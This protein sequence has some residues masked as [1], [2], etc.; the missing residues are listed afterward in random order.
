MMI[1]NDVDSGTQEQA[2]TGIHSGTDDESLVCRGNYVGIVRPN[3][4]RMNSSSATCAGKTQQS[5]APGWTF[6]KRPLPSR[7]LWMR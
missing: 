1:V 4:T 2:L 5:T 6:S 3:E 7:N